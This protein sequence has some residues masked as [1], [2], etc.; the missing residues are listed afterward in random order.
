MNVPTTE[1]ILDEMTRAVVETARPEQVLLFGSHARGNATADSD[2]DLLVV[3]TEPFGPGRSRRAELRRIRRALSRFRV[4]KDVLVYSR[5]EVDRWK[6]A[7]NHVVGR[8]FAEGRVL[9]PRTR[10]PLASTSLAE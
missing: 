1:A 6:A 3:E 2:V 10:L 4:P 9:W 7:A 8:A 5:D